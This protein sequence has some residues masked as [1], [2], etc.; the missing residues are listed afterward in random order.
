MNNFFN[1]FHINSF[2]KKNVFLKIAFLWTCYQVVLRK[3]PIFSSNKVE[4]D[5][6]SII[7]SH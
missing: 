4:D 2:R 7:L 3:I 6:F 5:L 1:Q